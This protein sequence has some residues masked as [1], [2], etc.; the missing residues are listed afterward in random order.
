LTIVCLALLVIRV[1][2]Y[3]TWWSWAG[4]T[5]W[6]PRFLVPA[7][8]ALLPFVLEIVRRL[9]LKPRSV[10]PA[11]ASLA[12]AGLL[13]VSLG[14][15]V[16]GAATDV[17]GDGVIV[18]ALRR[19]ALVPRGDLPFMVRATTPPMLAATTEPFMDWSLFP[20]RENAEELLERKTLMSRYL[21]PRVRTLPLTLA[22]V[23]FLVGL[24]AAFAKRERH[25]EEPSDG[26]T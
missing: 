2:F 11:A 10:A 13:V 24:S 6:G 5:G 20:I 25:P 8:P 9:D 18:E 26:Q 17:R 21:E 14:V 22:A 12:F 7:M 23:V 4:G 1:L 3:A 15:Q 19:D 16:V